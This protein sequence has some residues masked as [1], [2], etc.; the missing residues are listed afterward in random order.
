MSSQG[1]FADQQVV[2]S[3]NLFVETDRTSITG[4]SQSRGDEVSVHFEGSSIVAGDGELIR[5]TLISFD[6]FNNFFTVDRNN[7]EITIGHAGGVIAADAEYNLPFK[8]Y[9]SYADLVFEFALI[10]GAQIKARSGIATVSIAAG[11]IKN[12]YIDNANTPHGA[13]DTASSTLANLTGTKIQPGQTGNRLLDVTFDCTAHGITD[14][15]IQT[16]GLRGDAYMLLGSER[17]DSTGTDLTVPPIAAQLAPLPV[18]AGRLANS[19]KVTLT[20]NQIRVQG[21]FPIQ[22]AS[23]PYVYLRCDLTNNGGLESATLSSAATVA[24]TNNSDLTTSDIFA[25][26]RR[27]TTF[28]SYNTAADEY[29]VNLQQRKINTMK[30]KLTDS[31]ARP[32]GQTEGVGTAG[33][34]VSTGTTYASKNQDRLGNLSFSCVIRF[35]IIKMSTMSKLETPP[36]PMALPAR[37]A[38]QGVIYGLQDYGM[39]KSGV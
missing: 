20:T 28:I 25:K 16:K 11:G 17:M 33:G 1:R 14:F 15:A 29:F 37:K 21:Y 19:F 4:D 35:D 9:G 22:L 13:L 24:A 5:M 30:L 31:K 23:D 36:L 6:M 32:I 8:N 18:I 3:F 7:S 26:I 27:D 38:Q 39:T 12:V 2:N 10:V 34:L